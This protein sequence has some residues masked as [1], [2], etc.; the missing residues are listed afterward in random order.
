[1]AWRVKIAVEIR[2]ASALIW[3]VG[4]TI[5]LP[6]TTLEIR[7]G[8]LVY[9]DRRAHSFRIFAW[10]DTDE[11]NQG[12][13]QSVYAIIPTGFASGTLQAIQSEST[14]ESYVLLPDSIDVSTASRDSSTSLANV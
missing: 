13:E 1:M 7:D 6:G 10:Q 9:P 12:W 8:L 3:N 14:N 4:P 11:A 5:E 2:T